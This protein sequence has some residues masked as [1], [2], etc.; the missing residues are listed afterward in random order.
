MN[1]GNDKKTPKAKQRVVCSENKRRQSRKSGNNDVT[2]Y[3]DGNNPRITVASTPRCTKQANGTNTK[4]R[5]A[6]ATTRRSKKQ[7]QNA[8]V[9]ERL[10]A[11]PGSD[12][13]SS[14]VCKI[15]TTSSNAPEALVPTV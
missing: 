10:T 14:S 5:K 3:K 8:S 4:V 15:N 12:F 11:S 7:K 6:T 13:T 1:Q 2:T 9:S